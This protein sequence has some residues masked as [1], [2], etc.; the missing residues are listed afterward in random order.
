VLLARYGEQVRLYAEAWQRLTGEAVTERVL[1]FTA[2]GTT[3]K[4]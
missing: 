2:D 1:L 3:V 4:A